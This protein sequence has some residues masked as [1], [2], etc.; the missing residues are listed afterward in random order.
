M[1]ATHTARHYVGG[2]PFAVPRAGGPRLRAVG[3][4]VRAGNGAGRAVLFVARP[5][6]AITG[7]VRGIVLAELITGGALIL[8]LAVGGALADRARAGPAGPDGG[9]RAA[10]HHPGRPDRPD[11]G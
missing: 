1:I 8:L 11:A 9:H 3:R 7:Q 6:D 2:G 4:I 5:V 10:D